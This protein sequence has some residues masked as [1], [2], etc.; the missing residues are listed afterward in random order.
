LDTRRRRPATIDGGG[1]RKRPRD[2]KAS[3]AH[4][5]FG[6]RA[7]SGT[8][9]HAGQCPAGAKGEGEVKMRH[10]QK[11]WTLEEEEELRALIFSAKS[12]ETIAKKLNRTPMAIRNKAKN[13]K[14]PLKT[15]LI[16]P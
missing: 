14:L 2:C 9:D 6:S 12:I 4:C 13:L 15:V 11:F 5:G 10:T 8:Q 7:G 3:Q 16:S 1:W